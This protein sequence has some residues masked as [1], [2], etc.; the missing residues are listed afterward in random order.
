MRSSPSRDGPGATPSSPHGALLQQPLDEP[1]QLVQ[2]RQVASDADLQDLGHEIQICLNGVYGL[3][4]SRLTGKK[5]QEELQAS[6][7]AFGAVLS[8]LSLVYK[9]RKN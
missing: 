3:L 5:G 2:P 7:E 1:R 6:A 4:L 8:Y 9:E